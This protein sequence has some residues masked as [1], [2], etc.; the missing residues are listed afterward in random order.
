[1]SA[2]KR[3]G[4]RRPS[5][6]S[7]RPRRSL[8]RSQRLPAQYARLVRA[9]TRALRRAYAP[10]SQFPVGAAVLAN[11]GSIYA[12]CN[13]ENASYGLTLC[14]ERVAIHTAVANGRRRLTAIAVV[15]PAG[16]TLT[17]CGACRQVMEEFGLQTVIIAGP[18]GA[19]AVVS[20][21]ALLPIPF[22]RG[23]GRTRHAGL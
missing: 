4:R 23:L 11:D 2:V 12:G 18:R 3:A 9:A 8:T 14:A 21:P 10:Y 7:P 15:G 22:T 1:M 5:P 13:V 16:I 19:P 6:R 20:L 17:P